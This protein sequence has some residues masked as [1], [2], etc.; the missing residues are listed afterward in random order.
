[1]SYAELLFNIRFTEAFVAGLCAFGGQLG[2]CSILNGCGVDGS[3]GCG[4]YIDNCGI[5]CEIMNI[6]S[7]EALNMFVSDHTLSRS[8]KE[9]ATCRNG[10]LAGVTLCARRCSA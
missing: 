3:A 1:M 10:V 6:F 4:D 9:A 7:V 8:K 5:T 2:S